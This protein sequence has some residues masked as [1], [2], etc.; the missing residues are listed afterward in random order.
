MNLIRIG[1]I[2]LLAGLCGWSGTALA[3]FDQFFDGLKGLGVGKVSDVTELPD[4]KVTAGLKEA[5]QI[6]AD[7]AVNLTGVLDGYFRNQTIKILIPDQL[8]RFDQALRF[9]GYGQELDVLEEKMN[10]AAE[11]AAPLAKPILFDAIKGLT[12]ED[13]KRILQGGE[14]AATDY[15]RETTGEQLGE[16]FR[17][18]VERVMAEVG[19]VQQYKQLTGVYESIPFT[20]PPLFNIDDYVVG[21]SLDGLFVV[22][23]EQERNIR[24]NPMARVTDLLKEVFAK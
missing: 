4:S 16:T 24:E 2:S 21:K 5:L 23:G 12:F 8:Q 1:V 13:A 22:L 15:F 7:N 11:R 18:E 17:P 6:G 19:V 14:T 10:R 9:A 20:K 3:Q